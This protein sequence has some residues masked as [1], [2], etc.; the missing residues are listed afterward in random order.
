MM[1]ALND[2]VQRQGSMMDQSHQRAGG[3]QPVQ[4]QRPR[5]GQ[6]P[7]QQQG[8]QQGEPQPGQGQQ[9]ARGQ[10]ALR[11]ALGELMQQFG[12]F[13]GEV[14][15]P[16]TEADRAMNDA[17]QSLR[18]DDFRGAQDAQRRAL[19]ALQQGARDA[20]QQM[21]R[22]MGRMQ[23]G[24]GQGEGEEMGNGQ[25]GGNEFGRGRERAA[26]QDPLGRRDRSGQ[27]GQNEGSDVRVPDEMELQRT[28]EILRELRRRAGER[29]RPPIELD[30]IDRLLRRF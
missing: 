16:L 10:G 17:V 9:D 26:G 8:Q 21:A 20:A 15:A 25:Q 27:L 13:T 14:P 5:P 1:G 3:D 2:M 6:R 4:Q 22:Q 28:R 11:R 7:G 30:Y 19:E 24:E 29:D 12:D 23:P 18:R